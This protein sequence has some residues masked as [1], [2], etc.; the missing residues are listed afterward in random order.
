MIND[1]QNL[2]HESSIALSNFGSK[3][4]RAF[5]NQRSAI[6]L[7][8]AEQYDHCFNWL[9]KNEVSILRTK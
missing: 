5:K 9:A 4:F 8:E 7:F 2:V 1:Y 6:K 3:C